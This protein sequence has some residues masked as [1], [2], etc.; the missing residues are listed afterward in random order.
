MALLEVLVLFFYGNRLL[1]NLTQS[2]VPLTVA[3]MQ[4]EC[5]CVYIPLAA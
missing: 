2:G 3:L 4:I 1:V 5:D